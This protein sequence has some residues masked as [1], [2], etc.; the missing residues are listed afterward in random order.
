[1]KHYVG[2]DVSVKETSVCIVDESGNL[3]RERKVASHPE[4]LVTIVSDPAFSLERV[5]VE[6][7][8]CPNGC[9]KDWQK[10]ACPSSVSRRAIPR[11]SWTPCSR[12]KAT[13]TMHAASLT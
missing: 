12:T 5:G 9:L 11:H 8:P 13:G 4:D 2:L 1:M 7:A 10:R 3:C 6:A